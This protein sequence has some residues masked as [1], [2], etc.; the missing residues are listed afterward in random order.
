PET[1]KP[2]N[3]ILKIGGDASSGSRYTFS[4]NIAVV[5]GTTI[6][7]SF[8]VKTSIIFS[9]K[10]ISHIRMYNS[11][12]ANSS[13][14]TNTVGGNSYINILQNGKADAGAGVREY[15]ATN[16]AI[17]TANKWYRYKVRFVVPNDVTN[18][19]LFFVV[20]EPNASAFLFVRD[21]QGVIYK[22]LNA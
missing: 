20:N 14:Q 3:N 8:D 19:K 17:S 4:R 5:P 13:N 9:A 11:E 7:L 21:P 16:Q 10:S 12:K 1:D 18:V 15:E 22:D 2:T 6:E